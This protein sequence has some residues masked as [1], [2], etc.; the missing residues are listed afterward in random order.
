MITKSNIQYEICTNLG[1]LRLTEYK[2]RGI[3]YFCIP[4]KLYSYRDMM[5]TRFRG[6]TI[7][8]V[9]KYYGIN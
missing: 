1:T 7:E 9:L 4:G 5:A 6:H 8:E 3:S 2:I